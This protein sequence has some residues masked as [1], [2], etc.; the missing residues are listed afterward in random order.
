MNDYKLYAHIFPNKKRYVGITKQVPNR[1]WGNGYGYIS[2]P[3]M[4]NAIQK[5]GW[6]NIKHKILY[7]NL[8]KNEAEI[9]E[10]KI[11]KEWKTTNIKYGYNILDGGNL[12][13]GMSENVKKRISKSKKGKKLSEETKLKIKISALNKHYK[14]PMTKERKTKL[15]KA[16]YKSILM[17]EKKGNFIKKFN[18]IKDAEKELKINNS[19]I[20]QCCLNKR[21]TAG[22]YIWKYEKDGGDDLLM[23]QK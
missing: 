11:I 2:S 18:C 8:S 14:R 22:N 6:H 12:S 16:N 4:Y 1:R 15:L 19:N 20:S 17:F 10:I 3:L 13:N 9:L 7:E 5:Y 21:K 23:M